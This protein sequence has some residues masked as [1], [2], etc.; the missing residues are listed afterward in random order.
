[1]RPPRISPAAV[2]YPNRRR[3]HRRCPDGVLLGLGLDTN[4]N[5]VLDL[6]EVR[7]T[8]VICGADPGVGGADSEAMP[9]GGQQ[10][11]ASVALGERGS[12][13]G[14][15]AASAG[16]STGGQSGAAGQGFVGRLL[17]RHRS[18]EPDAGSPGAVGCNT[19]VRG[20]PWWYAANGGCPGQE[21]IVIRDGLN[22][23]DGEL[24]SRWSRL[25]G[26]LSGAGAC[27]S[28]AWDRR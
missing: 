22:G 16:G 11:S 18:G 20:G 1:M 23:V 26:D 10:T 14:R 3:G 8:Q 15:G 6:D 28:F 25:Y 19:G 5:G 2:P 9:Q 4:G 21:P 24:Y 13:A 27:A 12:P 17:W 7:G